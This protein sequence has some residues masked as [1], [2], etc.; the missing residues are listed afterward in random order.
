LRILK[1]KA[2]TAL[3]SRAEKQYPRVVIAMPPMPRG[4]AMRRM[5]HY[6]GKKNS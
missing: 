6:L 2:R 1:V 5:Q 3:Y 4:R